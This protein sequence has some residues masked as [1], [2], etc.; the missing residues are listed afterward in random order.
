[1]T[2][3]GYHT[4]EDR[5]NAD[6]IEQKGPFP[7]MGSQAFLG[8]GCYFWEDDDRHAHWWGK[9]HCD[10]KYVICK[11]QFGGDKSN[12]IDLVAGVQDK[13]YLEA[14]VSEFGPSIQRKF[15]TKQVPLCYIIEYPKILEG[16]PQKKGI[17]PFN[18]IRAIDLTSGKKT[19]FAE[20]KGNYTIF[21]GRQILCIIKD[22]RLILKDFRIVHPKKYVLNGH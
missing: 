22:I 17:F 21:G 6:E 15:G 13:R 16:T 4:V 19:S 1:M 5:E 12:L 7:S 20:G 14:L 11:G 2:F 8:T 18:L 10:G 9:V 3:I